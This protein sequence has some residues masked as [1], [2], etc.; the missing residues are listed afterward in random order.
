MNDALA[1]TGVAR[2]PFYYGWVNLGLAVLAMVGT[3]P[4]RTQGL[5]LVAEP[6]MRDL[7]LDRVRFAQIN[8][9]ATLSFWGR[10]Y[11]RAHL[12]RIQGAAQ[13][14]TV[15]GSAVGPLLLAECV[16]LTG[17]Y[18][19][20]FYALAAVVAALAVASLLVPVPPG[21]EPPRHSA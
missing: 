7:G 14:L 9:V 10:A 15:L 1:R 20:A 4:G 13:I 8:L 2:L 12:G 3:L 16:A 18:A 19:A 5:G 11:G 6:L 17:S 21:A